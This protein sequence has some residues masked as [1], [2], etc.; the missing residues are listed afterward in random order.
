[1][2]CAIAPMNGSKHAVEPAEINNQRA[3]NEDEGDRENLRQ[4]AGVE[5]HPALQHR[6]ARGVQHRVAVLHVLANEHDLL[7]DV[8]VIQSLFVESG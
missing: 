3:E 6:L 4:F 8:A 7:L 1:M 5:P 2:A